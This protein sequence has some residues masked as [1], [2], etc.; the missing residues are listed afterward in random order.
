MLKFYFKSEI[1]GQPLGTTLKIFQYTLIGVITG[2]LYYDPKETFESTAR[3]AMLLNNSRFLATLLSLPFLSNYLAPERRMVKEGVS[4]LHV[5]P[6][7]LLLTKL[8]VYVIFRKALFLI[9]ATILYPL[10]G[11]R[12]GFYH[13]LIF[14][15]TQWVHQFA[16]S[17][18]GFFI[19][20]CFDSK[21]VG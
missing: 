18:L 9:Y 12:K 14:V 2:F 21:T 6:T 17:A 19:S 1:S 8:F 5:S 16:K 13:W 20:A 3:K 4:G 15:V 7:V 10:A 11:L